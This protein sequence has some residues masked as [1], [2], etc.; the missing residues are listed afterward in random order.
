MHQRAHFASVRLLGVAQLS[1]DMHHSRKSEGP[2]LNR[3]A[4]LV[5]VGKADDNYDEH[6]YGMQ[7]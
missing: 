5:H 3:P 2:L 4:A 7:N 1:F 6:I